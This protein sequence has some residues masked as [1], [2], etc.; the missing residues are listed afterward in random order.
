VQRLAWLEWR[1]RLERLERRELQ[2]P[3]H[4]AAQARDQDRG[5]QYD[6]HTLKRI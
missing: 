3:L 5:I 6:A 4:P 1:E 2:E